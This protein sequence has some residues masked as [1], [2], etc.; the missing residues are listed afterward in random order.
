MQKCM[1]QVIAVEE[2]MRKIS[3][4]IIALCLLL[5]LQSC[6]YH[7]QTEVSYPLSGDLFGN[8]VIAAIYLLPLVAFL[9]VKYRATTI[10]VGIAA[11]LAGLYF[12]TYTAAIWATNLLVGWYIYS[13]GSLTHLA[14]SVLELWRVIV[15]NKSLKEVISG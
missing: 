8:I 14:A 7:G 10:L 15:P 11:C 4:I 3:A 2:H 5:P 13:A 1:A 9:R 12:V 6:T